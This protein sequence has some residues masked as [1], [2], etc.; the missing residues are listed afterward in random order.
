LFLI[1]NN[2]LI[3]L[4]ALKPP[5]IPEQRLTTRETRT[6]DLWQ[7]SHSCCPKDTFPGNLVSVALVNKAQAILGTIT[8]AGLRRQA[9][10]QARFY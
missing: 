1:A 2:Y 3:F 4:K 6:K 8:S 9:Q 10:A 5:A 7:P